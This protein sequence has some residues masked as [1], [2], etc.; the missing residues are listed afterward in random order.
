[1]GPSSPGEVESSL[2][3]Q[4]NAKRTA[5]DRKRMVHLGVAGG[6]RQCGG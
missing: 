1:V 4:S 6:G 5:S 2:H 3:E